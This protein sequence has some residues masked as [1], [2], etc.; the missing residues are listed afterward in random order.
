MRFAYLNK[1]EELTELKWG[2][3]EPNKQKVLKQNQQKKSLFVVPALAV[4]KIGNRIGYGG[5]YY[6]TYFSKI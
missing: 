4:D 1:L 5:G 6:D 3:P 2:I